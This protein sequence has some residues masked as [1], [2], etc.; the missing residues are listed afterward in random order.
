MRLLANEGVSFAANGSSRID[1][2]NSQ[3]MQRD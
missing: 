3:F 2:A 1:M